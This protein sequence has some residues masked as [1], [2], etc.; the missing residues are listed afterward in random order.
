MFEGRLV[1]E[2]LGLALA[3]TLAANALAHGQANRP[4]GVPHA[5]IDDLPRLSIL[6]CIL[7]IR[8]SG[9]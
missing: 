2:R 8:C 3:V 9:R 7:V 1:L 6:P 5:A 4:C